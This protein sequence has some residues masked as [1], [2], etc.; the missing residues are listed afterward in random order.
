MKTLYDSR[1]Q[2]PGLCVKFTRGRDLLLKLQGDWAE[3]KEDG[4]P[5][6]GDYRGGNRRPGLRPEMPVSKTNQDYQSNPLND[7]NEPARLLRL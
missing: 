3:Q 6:N 7:F 1:N 2:I 4:R 5:E